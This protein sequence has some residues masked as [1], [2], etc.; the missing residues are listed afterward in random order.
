MIFVK[1][2]WDY[3]ELAD[4]YL[5]RPDYSEA[6]INQLLSAAKV[7]SGCKVCDVGAG[8]GHLTK[9]LGRKGFEVHAVEPNDAMRHNGVEVTRGMPNVTW[10]EG[11]GEAT[12]RPSGVFPL[13]TFGSSFNVTDRP[14]ALAETARMLRPNGWFACMWNHRD[15]KDP[16]QQ[17][18][19]KVISSEIPGYQYGA[20]RED[21]T[22][23]IRASKIFSEAVYIEGSVTHEQSIEA[24]IEAWLS[25]ATLQR[26]A[27][28][29]FKF[30]V[31]KISRYLKGLGQ[32][33][34]TIPYTTRLWAAHKLS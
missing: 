2:E 4:A 11:T 14:L 33:V 16:I 13:V 1:T 27:G 17:E 26:Q 10:F 9:M 30:V 19:E 22:E 5:Q 34:I 20:R 24:C 23:V 7:P 28:E 12:G 29:R 8:T 25:H 32:P 21:Q 31:D 15:L 3:T 6:A 18:I